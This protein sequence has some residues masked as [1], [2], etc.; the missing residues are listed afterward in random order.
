MIPAPLVDR[1]QKFRRCTAP[2]YWE[3]FQSVDVIIVAAPET[4]C[5]APSSGSYVRVLLA[6]SFP[7]RAQ[8]R[9]STPSHSFIGL[10]VV[11]VARPLEQM[12]I[13][14]DHCQLPW[15]YRACA[16]AFALE[17][18]GGGFASPAQRTLE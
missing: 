2:R 6:S 3:L 16:V 11:A 14:A 9:Q 15:E 7:V 8:Y 17:G 5:T 12:P 4:P 18:A 13:G 1:A 10:P